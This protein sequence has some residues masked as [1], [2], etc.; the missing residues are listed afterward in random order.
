[1]PTKNFPQPSQPDPRVEG[2]SIKRIDANN[3]PRRIASAEGKRIVRELLGNDADELT[4][5]TYVDQL[6]SRL[7]TYEFSRSDITVELEAT[8][9]FPH[10]EIPILG[11]VRLER[12]GAGYGA[13]WEVRHQYVIPDQEKSGWAKLGVQIQTRI[14]DQTTATEL[15]AALRRHTR[16]YH[17]IPTASAEEEATKGQ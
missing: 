6:P 12:E 13:S 3:V 16:V 17:L 2:Y 5:S 1:M 4:F 15:V 7:L 14:D 8:R 9:V 11:G 10:T